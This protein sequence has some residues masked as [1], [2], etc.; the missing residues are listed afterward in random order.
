MRPPPMQGEYPSSTFPEEPMPAG[1]LQP[2]STSTTSAPRR[3]EESPT[4]PLVLTTPSQE[5]DMA[6]TDR[7]TAPPRRP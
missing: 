5:T 7:I 4:D 1:M 3:L 6:V 2:V